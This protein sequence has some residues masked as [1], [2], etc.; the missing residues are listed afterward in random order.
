MTTSNQRMTRALG[1]LFVLL[2][3]ASPATAQSDARADGLENRSRWKADTVVV[4][5]GIVMGEVD[6]IG[7]SKG[8]LRLEPLAG[9]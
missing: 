7:D 8:R 5:I 3:L 6:S 9:A 1:S 2:A 4:Q